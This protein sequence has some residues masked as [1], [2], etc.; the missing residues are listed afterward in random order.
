MIITINIDNIPISMHN[1]SKTIITKLK[2]LI[3]NLP[4]QISSTYNYKVFSKIDKLYLI[5]GVDHVQNINK[6]TSRDP[7]GPAATKD[8]KTLYKF[9]RNTSTSISSQ[10]LVFG[11]GI[12]CILIKHIIIK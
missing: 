4:Y 7:R 2:L 3:K 11:F 5:C 10:H 1:I 12:L 6:T 9:R 8:I